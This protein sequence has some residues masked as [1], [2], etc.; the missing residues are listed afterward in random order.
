[1]TFL[2]SL[3]LAPAQA[4]QVS[5]DQGFDAHGFQLAAFDGDLRDS[6]WV[7]RAGRMTTGDWFFGGLLEYANAPLVKLTENNAGE[8]EINPA[9]DHLVTLNLSGGVSLHERVRLDLA[10]P[11]HF[12]SF[13]IE[14]DYQGVS[15]GDL[16]ATAL[17]GILRPDWADKGFGLGASLHMDIPTGSP[18]RFLGQRTVAGG[19]RVLAHYAWEHFTVG[20]ELGLQFNPAIDLDNLR[21]PDQL[22]FGANVGYKINELHGLNLEARLAAGLARNDRRGA[23]TPSELALSYRHRTTS[24]GHLAAGLSTGISPGVGAARVRLFLGGGFGHVKTVDLSDVDGDGILADYDSCPAEPETVNDYLDEDGCPDALSE[25]GVSVQYDGEPLKGVET[26][27]SRDG[28]E[29]ETFTSKAK[30]QVREVVPGSTWRAS[31]AM[32]CL[33]G[34]GEVVVGESRADLV[35]QLAPVRDA[36]VVF[37]VVDVDGEPVPDVKVYWQTEGLGCVPDELLL[38]EGK[39][40]TEVGLGEHVLYVE[41]PDFRIH[42]QTVLVEPGSGE[43]VLTITLEPTKVD[44]QDEEIRILEKV[45]FETASAEIKEVSYGLL[46]EVATVL[47]AYPSIERVEVAGHTDSRG[48]DAYNLDL[49]QRRADAVRT[50]LIKDGVEPDR[51][52]AVGYGETRPIADNNRSSGRDQNRRVEFNILDD[53]SDAPVEPAPAE[54][55]PAE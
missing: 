30:P 9:L 15:L 25:L 10:L 53:A 46:D 18:T 41:A 55:A 49:S 13:D 4:Q 12:A 3:L 43:I 11:L 45:F 6:L 20:G 48:D 32:D 23:E 22:L 40:E 31:G 26:T 21:N 38:A 47:L 14:G 17:I 2:L 29:P 7:H 37:D 33:S 42:R 5:A 19:G 8:V 35:V 54:D 36:R 39:G 52:V 27:Q 51:L 34:D 50:F 44:V 1:M 24:G 28:G 16:R